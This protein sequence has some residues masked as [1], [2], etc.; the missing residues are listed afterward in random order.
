MLNRLTVSALLQS[1][2]ALLA[3]CVVSLLV[4]TAWQSWERLRATG[5]ISEVAQAST[6]AFKAMHNLRTDRS[7]TPRVLNGE[8]AV[9]AEIDRFLHGIHDA[10]M[11]AIRSTAAL[12]PSIPFAEQASL[13]TALNQQV[14]RS[15]SRGNISCQTAFHRCGEI[16]GIPNPEESNG[17]FVNLAV[18]RNIGDKRGCS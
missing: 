4:T 3:V 17:G 1:V 10:E 6:N 2:I 11:P 15:R 8:A 16:V 5:H 14:F 13:L 12:L 18:H 9:S 7:S